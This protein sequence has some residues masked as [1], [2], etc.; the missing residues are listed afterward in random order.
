MKRI[1][2]LKIM[3]LAR[4]EEEENM[5]QKDREEEMKDKKN[6]EEAKL[7]HWKIPSA[8]PWRMHLRTS[9]RGMKRSKRSYMKELRN[10]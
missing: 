3:G 5:K 1:T 9:C 2:L 6:K 7:H 4:Q 10:N 8:E